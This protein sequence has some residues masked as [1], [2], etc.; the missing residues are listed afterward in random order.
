MSSLLH[1]LLQPVFANKAIQLALIL[2]NNFWI[3]RNDGLIPLHYTQ[4]VAY[5]QY[6]SVSTKVPLYVRQCLVG[7]Y[8]IPLLAVQI[9]DRTV[10]LQ[11]NRLGKHLLD[12]SGCPATRQLVRCGQLVWC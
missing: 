8:S 3:S 11:F 7:G 1:E 4:R 10:S 9:T 2:C 6:Q 12:I 5:F